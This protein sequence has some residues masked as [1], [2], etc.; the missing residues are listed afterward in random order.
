MGTAGELPK[1]PPKQTVFLEDLDQGQLNEM[2]KFNNPP[3]LTNLGN[4]CYLNS[5]VQ[6]L[7]AV[8]ELD[9]ALKMYFF[10]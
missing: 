4:T 7:K 2:V 1:E 6:C 9:Q 5:T 8:P 10:L 3:G